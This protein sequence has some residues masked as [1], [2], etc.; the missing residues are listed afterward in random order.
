MTLMFLVVLVVLLAGIGQG[1]L[2]SILS[3]VLGSQGSGGAEDAFKAF[4]SYTNEIQPLVDQSKFELGRN[5]NRELRTD[6]YNPFAAQ[7]GQSYEGLQDAAGG[8]AFSQY[9]GGA[10]NMLGRQQAAQSAG[11]AMMAARAASSRGGVAFGGGAALAADITRRSAGDSAM[12]SAQLNFQEQSQRNQ[13]EQ[14]MNQLR[15]QQGGMG[16]QFNLSRAAGME[17]GV[18][19]RFDQRQGTLGRMTNLNQGF[20]QFNIG[21][22][23]GLAGTALSGGLGGDQARR[24]GMVSNAGIKFPSGLSI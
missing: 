16:N 17:S 8:V 3:G 1:F 11:S 2:G 13:F 18:A 4:K 24:S 14:Q 5:L 21:N 6:Q 7:L 12:N 19:A 9:Q 20:D 22:Q 10:G 15:L 23:Y